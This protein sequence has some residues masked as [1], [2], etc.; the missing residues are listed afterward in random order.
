MADI[1]APVPSIHLSDLG[2]ILADIEILYYDRDELRVLGIGSVE[3]DRRIEDFQLVAR[4]S[5]SPA[6]LEIDK[7]QPQR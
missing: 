2:I 4:A 5:I 1:F 6:C 7:A 3:N